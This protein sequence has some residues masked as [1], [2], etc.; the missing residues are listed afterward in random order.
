MTENKKILPERLKEARNR[1]G[2]TQNQVCD[3][4]NIEIGTLSG[5]EIGRRRPNTDMLIKLATLYSVS[6]D[7]LLG[8]DTQNKQLH[9]DDVIKRFESLDLED[10]KAW[11][12][13]FIKRIKDNQ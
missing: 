4:L 13:E 7:Y 11:L 9:K 8:I 5:Y 12:S 6:V 10:Q 2:L 1:R 3:R